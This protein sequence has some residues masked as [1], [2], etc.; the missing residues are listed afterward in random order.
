MAASRIPAAVVREV[1]ARSEGICEAM[2]PGVCT[3]AAD[4]IH[5]RKRRSQGGGESFENG[6]A[7]CARCHE[8]LHRNTGE[9]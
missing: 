4:H 2:V 9:A 6:L 8:Y 1:H 7:V 5:H 3:Y